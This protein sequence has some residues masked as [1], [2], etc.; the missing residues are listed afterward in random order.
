MKT[1]LAALVVGGLLLFGVFLWKYPSSDS[2]A[3]ETTARPVETV[4]GTGGSLDASE[5]DDSTRAPLASESSAPSAGAEKS[6][7]PSSA[8]PGDV[9][10]T[11]RV[12]VRARVVDEVGAPVA[13]AHLEAVRFQPPALAQS[14][15][16]GEFVLTLD[17]AGK[18][19]AYK[20]TIVLEVRA[21]GFARDR[22]T[23]T[24]DVGADLWL[25][26]WKLVAAGSVAGRVLDES[27]RGVSGA[28]V[29]CL[30][31][32]IS[33][34]EWSSRRSDPLD[35]LAAQGARVVT[36]DDGSFAL[37]DVP[38][39]KRRL[40]AVAEQW[41]AGATKTFELGV[42]QHL[43]GVDV[44]LTERVSGKS[45]SG[46]VVRSDGYGVP[47]ARIVIR[48]PRDSMELAANASGRFT[49]TA[50]DSDRYDVIAFDPEGSLREATASD[51]PR[52]TR[53][54]V[55]TLT[56]APTV[57]L[58]VVSP[59]GNPIE[60]YAANL[61]AA[62]GDLA[63]GSY[64][65]GQHPGGI[66]TVR[67]PGRAFVIDVQAPGWMPASLG[68]LSPAS[69]AK[70]L[71]ITL[72]PAAGL[73]GTVL[74][75]GNALRGA[76]VSIHREVKRHTEFNGFPVRCKHSAEAGATSGQDGS[77]VVPVTSPDRYFVHVAAEGWA[78]AELGPFDLDSNSTRRENIELTRGGSMEV[79][80][81]SSK[82]RDVAGH[83]VALSRGDGWTRTAR[84][85]TDGKLVFDLLTPGRWQVGF[86]E[87]EIDARFGMTRDGTKPPREIPWNCQVLEG[88]VTKFD[89]WI[90]DRGQ[91]PC[92]LQGRLTI[93]GAQADG[94][95][96]R[97][98]EED[99]ARTA[100]SAFE[101]AGEFRV[102]VT[103]PGSY[104]LLLTSPMGNPAEMLVILDRVQIKA[105]NTQWSLELE[106]GS[107]EGTLSEAAADPSK[108]MFHQW[109]RGTTQCLAP[110]APGPDGKFRCARVCAG[111]GRIVKLDPNQNLAKQQPEVVAAVEI[112][113]GKTAAVDV[114]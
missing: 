103:Q 31:S 14:G 102:S 10:H 34:I 94:W 85:G 59:D 75:G 23:I 90:E 77:F 17:F 13:N 12:T 11:S 15:P 7:T 101:P 66:T 29:G 5:I 39:G 30:N 64:E 16:S 71:E 45:I 47:W 6:S 79:Q 111:T 107:L 50:L 21:A 3:A 113:A 84:C 67:L 114:R 49:A 54:L 48:S 55:L 76:E 98:E 88:Q 38:H 108:L 56:E 86:V 97:L 4:R 87:K 36:G 68:P 61:R 8:A 46:R 70:R 26:E 80:V 18:Q 63:L 58:V 2:N 33:E 73:S 19:L 89:L 110:I 72:S 91:E 1:W 24:V 104:R 106:T 43:D 25:E 99:G 41:L 105:G 20:P 82:G 83:V 112:E 100:T 28:Q 35:E 96:A 37:E 22:R 95:Q 51:V 93:D 40:V 69:V 44:H 60:E 78:R 65:L 53:D 27:G 52:G 92:V 42:A 81:R 9:A 57:E 74:A 62:E 109:Q 32:S